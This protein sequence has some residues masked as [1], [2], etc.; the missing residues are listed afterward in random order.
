MP[1]PVLLCELTTMG[2]LR[3]A[4]AKRIVYPKDKSVLALLLICSLNINFLKKLATLLFVRTHLV[5]VAID[6]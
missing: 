2:L 1:Y 6:W 3:E 4:L 5:H